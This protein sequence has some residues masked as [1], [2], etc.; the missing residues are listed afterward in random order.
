MEAGSGFGSMRECDM[1]E[2]NGHVVHES[3]TLRETVNTY[4]R[5]LLV[6][7]SRETSRKTY[8]G[9]AEHASFR[10]LASRSLAKR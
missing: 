6:V 1:I 4:N 2:G 3:R 5:L 7:Q 8:G 10:F 9:S